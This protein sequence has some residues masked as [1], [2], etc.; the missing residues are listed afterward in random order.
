MIGRLDRLSRAAAQGVASLAVLLIILSALLTVVD[1]FMRSVISNPLFGTNDIVV[2]LLTVAVVGCFPFGL[3]VRQHIQVDLL[4]R[5]LG[6]RGFWFLEIFAN[7][8]T[9]TVFV[10]FCIEFGI[11]AE[12]LGAMHTGTQLLAIPLMPFWW[13]AAGILGLASLAQLIVVLQTIVSFARGAPLPVSNL[14]GSD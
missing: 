7:L 3:A 1:V 6:P 8:L 13:A 10:A 4:G 5:S 14:G 11:R 12:R 9:L 2:I